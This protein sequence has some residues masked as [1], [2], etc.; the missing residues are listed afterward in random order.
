MDAEGYVPYYAHTFPARKATWTLYWKETKNRNRGKIIIGDNTLE[1]TSLE[2][3]DKIEV[4][5]ETE[6]QIYEMRVKTS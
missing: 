2:K 4:P 5:A 6:V 1:D 3:S